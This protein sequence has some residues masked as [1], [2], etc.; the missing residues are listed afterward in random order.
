M[1][2]VAS[3]RSQRPGGT[4]RL[5][6]DVARKLLSEGIQVRGVVQTNIE[7]PGRS[8]CDM[9]LIVLP[10]GPEV[11]ITQDLGDNARGCRLDSG[12]LEQ[13]VFHVEAT[14]HGRVDLLIINKFGKRES[15]GR[16]FRSV[17]GDALERGIPVLAGLNA[18]N[19]ADFCR[20][21]G[22]LA[23]Y[24]PDDVDIILDWCRAQV[25]L[26]AV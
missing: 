12:A 8:K 25:R 18:L 14:L 23:E 1:V 3:V 24:L 4:D 5:L 11:R 13:A 17:I 16:G 26:E 2:N 19:D 6:S 22:E 20:F 21:A 15:E 9:D 10:H 7:R